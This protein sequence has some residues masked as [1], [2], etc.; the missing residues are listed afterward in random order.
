[1]AYMTCVI[2]PSHDAFSRHAKKVINVVCSIKVVG[3]KF[4]E[5]NKR[6]VLNKAVV[7]GF[8][9]KKE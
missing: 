3:E 2:F 7:G 6:G 8:F 4:H 5:K 9:G 1:M